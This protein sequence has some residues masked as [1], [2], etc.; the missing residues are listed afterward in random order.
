MS[1]FLLIFLSIFAGSHA[2]VWYRLVHAPEW[3]NTFTA[4]ASAL[5]MAGAIGGPTALF[6]QRAVQPGA[7]RPLLAVAFT[8]LGTFFFLFVASAA[9][10]LISTLGTTLWGAGAFA[11]DRRLWLSRAGASVSVV[12]AAGMALA[13]RKSVADGFRICDVPVALPR[14]PKGLGDYR[15]VQIS[16]L[17][18]APLLQRD[19]VERVVEQT[20]ALKPDCIVLT[21]DLVD[22]SVANLQEDIAPLG[23][24][25]APG[26]VYFVTGNHEYYSGADAWLAHFRSLGI[27]PLRNEHVVL[28]ADGHHFALAGIDDWTAHQFGG[29]HGA[30]LPRALAGCP[31]DRAVVLLAHQPRAVTQA[32]SMGVDLVLSGHTHGGQ[33]WPFGWLVRLVQPYVRGLHQHSER[34]YI[35][36]H[37][38][39]G[40]WG[41]PMRLGAPAE[42]ACLRLHRGPDAKAA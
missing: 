19:Y 41:P 40:Y 24:L 8:W 30:D 16:D 9:V 32:A 14:F 37:S 1:L 27:R 2:Y 3:P 6:A 10:H 5:L 11:P 31:E 20:M 12:V 18:V 39:T 42:I 22:G 36:V 35:Y 21:G 4:W 13:S 34:T 25:Q 15:I 7:L 17:H 38:G 33:L 23:R 26:G 29:D 28:G